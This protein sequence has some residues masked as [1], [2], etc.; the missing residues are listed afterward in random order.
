MHPV[1]AHLSATIQRFRPETPAITDLASA[2]A[3]ETAATRIAT[4][5]S[6]SGA[7]WDD[8]RSLYG[9][10]QCVALALTRNNPEFWFA[11]AVRHLGAHDA[12]WAVVPVPAA[13]SAA[14]PVEDTTAVV[15]LVDQAV[16]AAAPAAL[17]HAGLTDLA[18]TLRN[19]PAVTIENAPASLDAV[20]HANALRAETPCSAEDASARHVAGWVLSSVQQALHHLAEV[21]ALYTPRARDVAFR[22]AEP[23]ARHAVDLVEREVGAPLSPAAPVAPGLLSAEE[24]TPNVT[25]PVGAY[26]P[27][28][29]PRVVLDGK[30][31]VAVSATTHESAPDF[32]AILFD[33]DNAIATH[34]VAPC[35]ACMLRAR[36]I[37]MNRPVP[38]MTCLDALRDE[39]RLVAEKRAAFLATGRYSTELAAAPAP[40]PVPRITPAQRNVLRVLKDG[41]LFRTD[42][43]T[44]TG[45]RSQA[46]SRVATTLEQRAW[47]KSV[48]LGYQITDAG[49]TVLAGAQ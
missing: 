44:H 21:H 18:K 7:S 22:A 10:A 45:L 46:V 17:E 31:P 3:A 43:E 25:R 6:D 1:V 28:P 26:E 33:L 15:A 8:A 20:V 13:P 19:L 30:A 27:V 16:R 29:A 23:F 14:V 9:A 36:R 2:L 42:L 24:F 5:L 32:D 35:E 41:G 12:R 47:I 48:G 39:R 38:A 34:G 37:A 11:R 49:R 4:A 40:Q